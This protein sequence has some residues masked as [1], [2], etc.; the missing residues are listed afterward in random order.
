MNAP[1]SGNPE[2]SLETDLTALPQVPNRYPFLDL[3]REA[4]E[5]GRIDQ[6]RILRLLGAGGM[7]IVFEAEEMTLHRRV[8]LKVLRADQGNESE[9]RERFLREARAAAAINSD[10]VVT[11]DRKSVV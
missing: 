7:G 4:D 1:E 6:Y 10:H 2:V 5:I 8:A 3:P 9:S 11:I